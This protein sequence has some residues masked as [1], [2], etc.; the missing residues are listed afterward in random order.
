MRY[1]AMNFPVLPVLEEIET[2]GRMGMDFIELAM[3]PPQAHYRQLNRQ[4]GNIHKA[5]ARHQLGLVCHLPTFVYTA[6]LTDAIRHASVKEVISALQTAHDLGAEKAVLHP[7]YID[8]LARY[9]PQHALELAMQSLAEIYRRAQAKGITLCIENMF[10]HLGPF[11]SPEDFDTIFQLFPQLKLVLDIG[12]ANIGD[13]D[14][15]RAVDFIARH[16]HRLEHLHVS[17]NSGQGDE[18]LPI[19]HGTVPFKAV[20]RALY[21]AG[22]DKTVTLEIFGEDRG[23]LIKSR[24]ALEKM[25]GPG[26]TPR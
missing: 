18:H 2:V 4:M 24:L 10:P 19:G 17:D 23:G 12:H 26:H 14:G 5:L 7:G 22:F 9:V 15:R 1:G 8:G 25:F 11:A 20:A 3:D 6:H 21:H 13:E 16:G